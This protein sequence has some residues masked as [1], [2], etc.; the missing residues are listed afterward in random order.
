VLQATNVRLQDEL[1]ATRQQLTH[2]QQPNYAVE[3]Q[4]LK[5]RMDDIT[6]ALLA[7]HVMRIIM[8]N[9]FSLGV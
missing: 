6:R 8:Q 4:A 5:Q 1:H 3:A 9:L 7:D 2:Q